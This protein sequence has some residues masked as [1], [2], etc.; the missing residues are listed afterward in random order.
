MVVRIPLKLPG[1]VLGVVAAKPPGTV[2]DEVP[3]MAKPQNSNII[4]MIADILAPLTT[5]VLYIKLLTK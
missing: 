4:F 2:K 1:M 3:L 5:P